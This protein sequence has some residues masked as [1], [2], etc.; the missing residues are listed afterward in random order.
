V[1]VQVGSYCFATPADAGP[2]ACASF[3]PVSHVDGSTLTSVGCSAANADGSLTMFRSSVDMPS[4]VETRGAFTLTPDYPACVQMDYV[5]AAEAVAGPML[6]V[7]V[8][9]WG[10]WKFISFLGWGRGDGS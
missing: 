2:H 6:A 4:G 7:A 8:I 3:V 1:T 5:A 10:A 9:C